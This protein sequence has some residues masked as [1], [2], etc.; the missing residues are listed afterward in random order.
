MKK[1]F[2]SALAALV[3]LA[4][5]GA[6]WAVPVTV[7]TLNDF[8]AAVSDPSGDITIA[9]GTT[10][11]LSA[12]LILSQDNTVIRGGTLSGIDNLVVTKPVSFSGVTFTGSGPI[13]IDANGDV[14]FAGNT[15]GTIAGGTVGAVKV[16]GG[17][18]KFSNDFSNVTDTTV[19]VVSGTVTFSGTN[20]FSTTTAGIINIGGGTATF[21]G[22][23]LRGAVSISDGNTT[24]SGSTFDGSGFTGTTPARAVSVSAGT[25]N[26]NGTNNFNNNTAGAIYITGGTIDFGGNL[27][28]NSNT[29]ADGGAIYSTIPLP[30]LGANFIFTSNNATSNGG[31][32]Y[33]A[34]INPV[35]IS[36]GQFNN[37]TATGNG[38]AIYASG[39]VNMTDGRFGTI[40]ANK[41][42]N[43][44]AIYASGTVN[45]SGGTLT[46]NEATTDG[47]AIYGAG[48]VNVSGDSTLSY[49]TAT[50]NG[51]AIRAG[52]DST[53]SGGIFTNNTADISGG[54][55]YATNLSNTVRVTVNGGSFERNR[56]NSLSSAPD[57]GGGAIYA[58]YIDVL[59]SPTA[60]VEFKANTAAEYGGALYSVVAAKL[61]RSIFLNNV[62]TVGGAV[63]SGGLSE[64]SNCVFGYDNGTGNTA[65]EDGGAIHCQE[66][67]SENTSFIY[68]TAANYGGAVYLGSYEAEITSSFFLN[69][70]ATAGDGGAIYRLGTGVRS[71]TTISL[72]VF[73][74]NSSGGDGGALSLI[75]YRAVLNRSLFKMNAL[76]NTGQKGG[77]A[78]I[79]STTFL[80][81]NC[82]FYLNEAGQGYGG[83]VYLDSNVS[84]STNNVILYST[85]FDNKAGQGGALYTNATGLN[86]GG[87]IY[88]GNEGSDCGED[89]L[90]DTYS[91][92]SLGYNIIQDYGFIGTGGKS[93]HANWI[94]DTLVRDPASKGNAINLRDIVPSVY[95]AAKIE[96]GLVFGST[97]APEP[98][99]HAPSS[100]IIPPP[101]GS[102]LTITPAP[103]RGITQTLDTIALRET[104]ASSVNPALNRIPI[105]D[106]NIRYSSYAP[107]IGSGSPID[108]RGQPRPSPTIS[109]YTDVGAYERNDGGDPDGPDRPTGGI[110]LVVM[111]G[112]PNTL[113]RIGQTA[114]LTATVYDSANRPLATELVTWASTNPR[115]ASIDPYGNLIA[116]SPGKV[117]ITV[118]TVGYNSAGQHETDSRE[119]EV[120]DE[121]FDSNI[122]KEIARMLGIFNDSI[123]S[124]SESLA[125]SLLSDFNASITSKFKTDFKA[126]YG[127]DAKTL[128][129]LKSA[130]SSPFSSIPSYKAEKWSSAKP[131][132]SI[133]LPSMP[134]GGGALLPVIYTWSLSWD[135]VSALLGRNV[136][137]LT[138]VT[139]LFGHVKIVFA[140]QI[141][142]VY[143]VVDADG[144]YG[145]KATE[146]QT[147]GA[148]SV[149]SVNNGV[150][151][152]LSAILSDVSPASDGKP[153]LIDR[154][155]TL[156]DGSP[157]GTAAGSMWLLKNASG[158]GGDGEGGGGG[159]CDAGF[160]PLALLALASLALTKVG[161]R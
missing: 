124:Y 93:P 157:N 14:D 128:T 91:I 82:T 112:I 28:F 153:K 107:F 103:L 72:S 24:F 113:T 135:D 85:F 73:E 10:I 111:S 75:G 114:T 95:S 78:Y 38:G 148:L 121:Y 6:G 26:F 90:R 4:G 29:A 5:A 61:R 158:G 17:T 106:P 127:V 110:N 60:T 134:S 83:A 43:G 115:I 41:A 3:I 67:K 108:E 109:Q 37:N 136:T 156:A 32:V 120:I 147:A 21:G 71:R 15:L 25:A 123:S 118:T 79:N 77:A 63:F 30:T 33:S 140:P 143:P 42:T 31:A 102:T 18:A 160:G 55:I 13:T 23:M 117:T 11:I 19:D 46:T 20:T 92:K 152:K 34:S 65:T 12:Q 9:T 132:I 98:T 58:S 36:G 59:L 8:I 151:L 74:H 87:S 16:N 101:A 64:V 129:E 22:N 39:V 69:N 131:S 105:S 35:T 2:L 161:K 154:K 130:G 51:G 155:L 142:A 104:T 149:T 94:A 47:G 7:S 125:F 141:G 144:A 56:S 116:H 96:P 89:V 45:V 146:A 52:A 97:P 137:S 70:K 44:G 119:L 150:T 159:G 138:N 145:V 54:A 99:W 40:T 80:S 53:I 84:D 48:A 27:N 76:A 139:E 122:D 86:M 66:L 81:I 49:N 62:A 57:D 126:A 100:G 50:E 1:I 68:N 88:V 133:T